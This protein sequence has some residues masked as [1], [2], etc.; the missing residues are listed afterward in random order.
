MKLSLFPNNLALNAGPVVAAF[1]EGSRKFGITVVEN[2]MSADVAVVWSLLWAGRM[3][4]NQQIWQ[5]FRQQSKPIVFLEVGML[6]RNHTWRL[7]MFQSDGSL[8]WGAGLD[9]T[10]PDKFSIKLQDWRQKG[11]RIV[12]ACQRHESQQWQG[13][14]DP[15]IWLQNTVDLIRLHSDRE[16][17]VRPHP[18]QRINIPKG[19][20]EIKPIQIA[21][22]YDD[23]DF[24]QAVRGAHAI[25]NWTSAPGS[26]AVMQGIP[27]FVGPNS[28]AA[29][30]ANLDL[31]QIESPSMPDR[32]RWF[33]DICHTEWTLDELRTAFP[34]SRL[35]LPPF[36]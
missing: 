16:I 31:S 23:F 7:G 1:V 4:G 36:G 12:I 13:Q 32:S 5:K 27:A 35:F 21:G 26:L 24:N 30:V 19:C 29:P 25:I 18:R 28:L 8:T 15:E 20:V 22:S 3:R 17:V 14:P 2:D 10:R 33:L 6:Q 11:D 34:I 9:L